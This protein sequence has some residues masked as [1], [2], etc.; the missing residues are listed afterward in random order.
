M[1][2]VQQIHNS[3]WP[4]SAALVATVLAGC[5]PVTDP[6]IVSECRLSAIHEARGH[7]LEASDVGE[8][9]EACM[10]AKGFAVREKS[11]ECSDDIKGPI[12]PACYYPNTAPGRFAEWARKLS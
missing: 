4:L 5:G 9:S 7:R 3:N 10:L 2:P 1:Q 12:N 8:L 11:A 6:R